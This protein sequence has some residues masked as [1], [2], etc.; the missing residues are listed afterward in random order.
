MS[1]G[2]GVYTNNATSP[3]TTVSIHGVKSY[4]GQIYVLQSSSSASATVVSM[5]SADGKT[6]TPLPGLDERPVCHGFCARFLNA[7]GSSYDILYILDNTT[8]GTTTNGD[9]VKFSLVAGV[10]T[11]YLTGGNYGFY[12][13]TFGGDGL[14]A[15]AIPGGGA[16]LYATT[17]T[18][19]PG[20]SVVQMLDTSGWNADLTISGSTTLYTC[21]PTATLKGIAFA[22][23]PGVPCVPAI[24]G[25]RSSQIVAAGTTVNFSAG[26]TGT[27]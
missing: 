27:A 1:D 21:P 24:T 5:M 10:W 18:G 23:V 13:Q 11:E 20:N 15:R 12:Q 19:A 8:S 9:I 14:C 4:G 3:S 25:N 22:P 6:L 2:G 7:N 26:A 16:A 17:A